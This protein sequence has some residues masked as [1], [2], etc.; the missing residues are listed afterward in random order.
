VRLTRDN[1][2][3]DVTIRTAEHE[4]Y[5]ADQAGLWGISPDGQVWRSRDQAKTWQLPGRVG[6]EPEALLADQ[7]RLYATVVEVGIVSS[8]DGGQT[9][10]LRYREGQPAG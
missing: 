8:A 6:G 4:T 10:E 9:W 7:G 1:V 2:L 5:W 3:E